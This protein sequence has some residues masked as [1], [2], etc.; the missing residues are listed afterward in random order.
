MKFGSVPTREAT[1]AVLAHSLNLGG[2]KFKKGRVLSEEDVAHLSAYTD[3]IT[4]ARLETGDVSENEAARTLADTLKGE[5]LS[6]AEAFTGRANLV[7]ET[8]GVLR[9]GA[10][11]AALNGV[12]EA[13]TL[14]TL[15]DYARVSKGQ[16]TATVKIIP[17]AVH[18][19]LLD[20]AIA[21]AS[22]KLELHP[23]KL[24]SAS[25]ILT[26]T[27]SMK[28]SLSAKA[29]TVLRARLEA[30]R[31]LDVDLQI[32]PHETVVVAEAI[33]A[34]K[35]EMILILGGSATSDK[36]DVCPA[37][38]IAAGGVLHRFGMPVDP[39]NLLFIGDLGNTPVI[40]L[41]GCVR[42]PA[43][44]GADWVLE[45][46]AAQLPVTSSDIASMGVG[47]LLKEIPTRPQP[48]QRK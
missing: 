20:Q 16:M 2:E 23:F 30:L 40:G 25:L 38:L 43:L 14:A 28:K 15:A 27:P 36:N 11:V 10:D 21:A 22:G 37:A 24:N 35:G 9:I 12:D 32:V 4:V 46:V 8:A 41:P 26:E 19:S 13:I 5:N 17:Y 47:G 29:E 48:R 42:S 39:G 44:N 18:T 3:Q 1:G 45:R 34:A 7:A 31:I 33:A 6:V